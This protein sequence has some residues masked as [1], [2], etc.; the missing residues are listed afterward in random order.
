M[1]R[2]CFLIF[3]AL[4]L[5]VGMASAATENVTAGMTVTCKGPYDILISL[6]I[7]NFLPIAQARV[8]YNWISVFVIFLVAAMASQRTTRF[9]GILIPAA[10]VL[11]VY[12]GWF[13]IPGTSNALWGIIVVSVVLAVAMYMKGSLHE[14]FGIAGPGSVMF[15]IV[16]YI[17]IL[18]A[19]VGFVNSTAIW[20]TNAAPSASTEYTN[21]DLQ[22]EIAGIN[23]NVGIIDTL[24]STANILTE[25][26]VGCLQMFV[27]MGV[28]L[29]AFSV[30][31]AVIYP[32][33]PASPYGAGLLVLIQLGIYII[34]FAAIMR[35]I[36]PS[37]EGDF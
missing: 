22:T 16:F 35:F 2:T 21:I 32:W 14:R 20:D 23:E 6:A 19:V 5:L 11:L 1:N 12:F 28:A 27:S 18:Q 13:T 29:V 17:L 10:A 30:V 31:L 15:N 34:Y 8:F 25:L 24:A 37:G 9:F 36:R 33:I 4:L 7:E 26:A 3:V